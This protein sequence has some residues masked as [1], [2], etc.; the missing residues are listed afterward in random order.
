M[1]ATRKW[2]YVIVG[3]ALFLVLLN[4]GVQS[5]V[6]SKLP[7]IF[8]EN[9]AYELQ[10][11]EIDVSIFRSSLTLGD[12]IIRPKNL[13]EKSSDSLVVNIYE[14]KVNGINLFKLFFKDDIAISSIKIN[15]PEIHYAQFFEKQKDSISSKPEN[16]KSIAIKSFEIEGGKLCF[17]DFKEKEPKVLEV[18]DVNI[19]LDNI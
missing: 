2:I 16:Q 11:K 13:P 8:Q 4:F 7:E 14:L 3:L 17:S 1:T 10:F 12:I 6:K 5:W 15:E 19:T 18:T 9:T